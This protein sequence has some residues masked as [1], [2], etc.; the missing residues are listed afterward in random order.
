VGNAV[1]DVN[2]KNDM[3]SNTHEQQNLE[4]INVPTHSAL[5]FYFKHGDGA[6]A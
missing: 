3:Y 2:I 1:H 5:N 4:V 6:S